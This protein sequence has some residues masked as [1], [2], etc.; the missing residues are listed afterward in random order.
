MGVNVKF[1]QNRA[2]A[3]TK[4]VFNRVVDS[5][6]ML[7]EIGDFSADRMRFFAR[8]G[9]SIVTGKKFPA[10]KESTIERRRR[11]KNFNSTG[12]LFAEKKSNLTFTGQLLRSIKIVAMEKGKV[13]VGPQGA[14]RATRTGPKSSQKRT[15]ISGRNE[16]LAVVHQEG[17][18]AGRRGKSRIPSRKFIGMDAKGVKRI[19]SIVRRTL[20][21]A[22][23]ASR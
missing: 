12:R 7:T 4:L 22:L 5:K 20:R 23:I 6:Q 10:L 8:T 1:N 17:A 11:L 21:R 16:N 14:R 9:K 19:S 3:R 13:D 18:Q 15:L 2:I